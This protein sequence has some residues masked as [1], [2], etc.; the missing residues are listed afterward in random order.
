MYL[1]VIFFIVLSLILASCA[2]E[3]RFVR[4]LENI[5]GWSWQEKM[6]LKKR[7][8]RKDRHILCETLANGYK[9]CADPVQGKY[10]TV[11]WLVDDKGII[12]DYRYEGSYCKLEPD[13]L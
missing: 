12:V 2:T 6:E 3:A 8:A 10:C 13:L 5:K 7:S 4:Y 9:E 11:Y 1:R